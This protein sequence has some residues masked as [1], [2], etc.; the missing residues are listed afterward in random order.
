MENI[1]W[2]YLI[3]SVIVILILGIQLYRRKLRH[4]LEMERLKGEYET[5]AESERVLSESKLEMAEER[6]ANLEKHSQE[7][8][9]QEERNHEN[10]LREQEEQF[11]KK[12]ELMKGEFEKLANDIFE[13][14]SAGLKEANNE[15]ISALLNPLK[16]KIDSFRK[17]AEEGR[18]SDV[19]RSASIRTSIGHLIEETR[20]VGQDANNLAEALK[21]KPKMQGNWGEMILKDILEGSGLKEGEE[22]FTQQSVRDED[23][24]RLIPDVIVK[25]PGGKSII[26][27]SKVS[28]TA[29]TEYISSESEEDMA[30][31]LKAHLDSVRKHVKEL[32]EKNYSSVVK[33]SLGFVLMFMP[34]EGAYILAMQNDQKLASDAYEKNVIIINPTNLMLALNL[35]YNLWQSEKQVRNVDK[36]IASASAL[37]DKFANFS[38]SF[39]DIRSKITSLQSSYEKAEGQLTT[40]RGNI[41][42]R[43]SDFKGYG[44]I[45]ND[46]INEELLERADIYE[47]DEEEESE[48]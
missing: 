15:N 39:A 26:I 24:N 4:N 13:K 33:G 18:K 29:Y 23:N 21:A 28:L 6:Y 46:K 17:E 25:Y 35:I 5:K 7:L 30:Q 36:I 2:V 10:R 22:F 41:V 40:G 3:V 20:R 19:D 47:D 37:Y 42:K 14:K 31:H 27:D 16:E 45:A 32:S 12:M 44:V 34:N 48:A 38:K 43:L 11:D 9:E 1:F 8:R